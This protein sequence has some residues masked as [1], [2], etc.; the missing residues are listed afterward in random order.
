[1][2]SLEDTLSR[3]DAETSAAPAQGSDLRGKLDFL[4]GPGGSDSESEEEAEAGE[5]QPT[6]A[7]PAEQ[8][9]MPQQTCQDVR[10]KWTNV[11]N[12]Q[13]REQ[14]LPFQ[15][16]VRQR[17]TKLAE[18]RARGQVPGP[19]PPPAE[20]AEERPPGR[21]GTAGRRESAAEGPPLARL[22]EK[23]R[24]DGEPVSYEGR[25]IRSE[26]LPGVP[27]P[28]L[29]EHVCRP[30]KAVGAKTATLPRRPGGLAAL[31]AE[32][33]AATARV[34]A[35]E[36]A[37]GE[38]AEATHC[39]NCGIPPD[40]QP[41]H[42]SQCMRTYYCS[43]ECQR[44]DWPLHK[45][46]CERRPSASSA[47][48]QA[49]MTRA[50]DR[51]QRLEEARQEAEEQRRQ[52]LEKRRLQAEEQRREQA[53]ESRRRT[54]EIRQQRATEA[55]RKAEKLRL[56]REAE[57]RQQEEQARLAQEA[58]WKA[59]EE[60]RHRVEEELSQLKKQAKSVAEARAAAEERQ[61]RKVEVA[62]LEDYLLAQVEQQEILENQGQPGQQVSGSRLESGPWQPPVSAAPALP[63]ATAHPAPQA[64]FTAPAAYDLYR[65]HQPSMGER[66]AALGMD[67]L[68]G[69]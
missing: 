20:E 68:R 61:R 31:V 4:F 49:D 59:H 19:P 7:E 22:R 33:Q 23:A 29:L 11:E 55:R 36:R 53:R 14:R 2:P 50:E 9:G 8:E 27:A 45:Q 12:R 56:Q 25:G 48:A 43:R 18:A 63:A 65:K 66:L 15:E 5:A 34:L 39:A 21:Q 60:A 51:R 58:A 62:V 32:A 35:A 6:Q 30:A 38:T 13:L 26:G 1:V 41:L 28:L 24:A 69:L 10:K 44:E 42:C 3:I 40:E 16:K 37:A 64:R 52:Q 67:E 46:S 47:G 57:R 54:A 17:L